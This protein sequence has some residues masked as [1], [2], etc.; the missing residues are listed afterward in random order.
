MAVRKADSMAVKKAVK[1]SEMTQGP[2][3]ISGNTAPEQVFL[4]S[5]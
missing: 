1:A 3:P 5:G 4:W 2:F